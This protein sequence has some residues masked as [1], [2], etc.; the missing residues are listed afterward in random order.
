M[1]LTL[2]EAKKLEIG[3][4]LYHT[5]NKNADGSSQRWRVTG[6]VKRWKRAPERIKVPIKTGLYNNSYLTEDDLHLLSKKC[7]Y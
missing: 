2:E 7:I 3:Q 1:T 5:I 6:K 4:I